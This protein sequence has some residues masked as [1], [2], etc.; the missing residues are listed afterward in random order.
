MQK[1]RDRLKI[2]RPDTQAPAPEQASRAMDG[3][4]SPVM[5]MAETA[6][7]KAATAGTKKFK[8]PKLDLTGDKTVKK[9]KR[10]LHRLVNRGLRRDFHGLKVVENA[11]D[12]LKEKAHA[13]INGKE[14]RFAPGMLNDLPQG[15]ELLRH[16]GLQ[17]ELEKQ[18]KAGTDLRTVAESLAQAAGEL[19]NKAKD[20]A[21]WRKRWG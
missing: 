16:E 14:I 9:G 15:K 7:E 13:I 17:L 1:L 3:M 6:A 2:A 11:K 18:L 4:Q 20:S 19:H 21:K 10:A 12:V 8:P 5:G